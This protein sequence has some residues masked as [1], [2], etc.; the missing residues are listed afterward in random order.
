MLSTFLSLVAPATLAAALLPNGRLNANFPPLPL[1]PVVDLPATH[2][3][4]SSATLPPLNTTYI[5]DQL[6]DHSNPSLGTFQQRYWMNWEFYVE[7]GPIIIFTPGE[8]NA[9]PYTGYLTNRTINGQIA[10]QEKGAT[11]VIEHRF[12]GL[13]NP[14]PDLTVESLK[15]LTI[16]LGV[17][18]LVYFAKTATLPMP[19]GDNVKPDQVP[20]VLVGG[21]YSGALTAFTM[22]NQP[23]VFWAGYSSSGVVESIVDFW[24]YFEPIRE[25]MPQ[26]CSA[27]VQAVIAHFDSI[28]SNTRAFNALKAKFGMADVVHPDDAVG[29][30]RNNLWDWQALSPSSGPGARFFNFCDA[31]E[32]DNGKVAPAGGFGLSHALD[33]WSSY[34]ANTYLPLSTSIVSLCGSANRNDCLG[35]YDRNATY[36]TDTTIDNSGRSWTWIVCNEVGY[37]QDAAPAGHP[38]LVSHLDQPSSDERQCEWMFPAAFATPP[39]PPVQ[40]TNAAYGGWDMS[41]PRLFF[42]TGM[43]DPWRDATM[44]ADGVT[45]K[46]TDPSFIGLS[47]G[48]HCSDLSTANGIVD[49]TVLTVQTTALGKIHEWLQEFKPAAAATKRAYGYPVRR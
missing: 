2:G 23:D 34:F 48:F 36:Y 6:I 9:A 37:F 10:Q 28:A 26:N 20:W 41:V 35:T 38:T 33:A 13:S 45:P 8:A 30:L 49:K 46:G 31:L 27:D 16:Q 1:P 14:Y 22:V 47:D 7:G 39:V 18:D 3:P 4:L 17:E 43:R 12:F 42:A 29:A 24:Q 19:G 15:Y 44:S 21:S 32:V 25:H 40:K 11:I 5:F